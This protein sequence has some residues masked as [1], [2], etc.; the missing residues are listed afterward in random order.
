MPAMTDWLS[1]FKRRNVFKVGIAYL[2][3]AWVL[4]QIADVFAPQLNL[5]D[6]APRLITLIIL[7]GFPIA[8][9]LA[10]IFDLTPQVFQLPVH[11]S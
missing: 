5:P 4:I 10:W 1:E 8:L 7:L 9:V 2:V 6:W 3:V 11:S